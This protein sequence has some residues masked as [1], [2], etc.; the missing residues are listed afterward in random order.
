MANRTF[1]PQ[2]NLRAG[3]AWVDRSL[4]ERAVRIARRFG[5]EEVALAL[6]G[7]HAGRTGLPRDWAQTSPDYHRAWLRGRLVYLK[8]ARRWVAGA[9]QMLERPRLRLVTG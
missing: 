6:I 5:A 2:T 1:I 9:R 4:V 8:E 3:K 7:H